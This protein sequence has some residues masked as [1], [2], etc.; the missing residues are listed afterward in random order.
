MIMR[1]A[2]PE[3][4]Y[5]AAQVTTSLRR[6]HSLKASRLT[7]LSV[8]PRSCEP[9]VLPEVSGLVGIQRLR[10]IVLMS[11]LQTSQ[12]L[13][14]DLKLARIGQPLWD[15]GPCL[16][17]KHNM[18]VTI[19]FLFCFTHKHLFRGN[20]WSDLRLRPIL[21]RDGYA[22]RNKACGWYWVRNGSLL[23]MRRNVWY[24]G[25]C[26]TNIINQLWSRIYPQLHIFQM[27][28]GIPAW[29][30]NRKVQ[31]HK[32]P[33]RTWQRW[34][35]CITASDS[36]SLV[37][38]IDRLKLLLISTCAA[39]LHFIGSSLD[40]Y[41]LINGVLPVIRRINGSNKSC[42]RHSRPSPWTEAA[43]FI[44]NDRFW[45]FNLFQRVRDHDAAHEDG[46]YACTCSPYT[47]NPVAP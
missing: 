28:N 1:A 35:V 7:D 18:V 10:I 47:A 3:A 2:P 6:G 15:K 8:Q 27:A 40:Y 37:W 31:Q 34:E 38:Y 13:R 33:L 36:D 4:V 25:W 14:M 23:T 39:T 32:C 24:K 5:S 45:V 42:G 43:E 16:E 30:G 22:N 41:A 21:K 26:S 9:I 12:A 19:C 46:C 20:G 17:R 29:C 11:S 44:S